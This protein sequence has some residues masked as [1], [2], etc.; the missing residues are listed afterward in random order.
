MPSTSSF[1]GSSEAASR[2][3][4]SA[5]IWRRRCRGAWSAS[6]SWSSAT[7]R[8]HGPWSSCKSAVSDARSAPCIGESARHRRSRRGTLKAVDLDGLAVLIV[9]V[10]G[11]L[12]RRRQPVRRQPAAVAVQHARGRRAPLQLARVPL[13][14]TDRATARRPGAAHRLSRRR[15]ERRGSRGHRRRA[16]RAGLTVRTL[17]AG[18]GNVLRGDDGFGVEVIRRLRESEARSRTSS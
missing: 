2:S 18:F 17:V 4:P 15:R 1:T 13:R 12:L 10:G 14:R 11:E 9:N 3:R 6:R 8:P 7:A 16:G 5:M